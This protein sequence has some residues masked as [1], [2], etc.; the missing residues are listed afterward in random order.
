MPDRHYQLV[1]TRTARKELLALPPRIS[2][3][4]E[5]ALDRILARLQEG[6]RPQDMKRLQGRVD[7]FRVD[8][9]EYRILLSLDD[10]AGM[11]TVYRIRHRKDVYRNL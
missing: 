2:R 3:Q 7:T 4:I 9:G 8:S 11:V 1:V 10:V 5:R 6:Q